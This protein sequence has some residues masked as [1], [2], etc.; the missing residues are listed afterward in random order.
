MFPGTI[1]MLKISAFLCVIRPSM[2][3]YV[4]GAIPLPLPTRSKPIMNVSLTKMTLAAARK[5]HARASI[6]AGEHVGIYG[7][8]SLGGKVYQ[9]EGGIRTRKAR[10]ERN[11]RLLVEAMEA[12]GLSQVEKLTIQGD[13][14]T[15]PGFSTVYLSG[16]TVVL[17]VHSSQDKVGLGDD[18]AAQLQQFL[19]A[20][21]T[22]PLTN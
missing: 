18:R 4:V 2:P 3:F 13:I 15:D 20:R 12:A 19:H 17:I 21:N 11:A 22:A 5:H 16:S 7:H 6:K 14:W 9:L 1:G 10:A 8:G